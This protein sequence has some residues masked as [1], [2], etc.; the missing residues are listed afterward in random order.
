MDDTAAQ[1]ASVSITIAVTRDRLT[2]RKR[3]VAS[4]AEGRRRKGRESGRHARGN[5]VC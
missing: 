4:S 5:S 1:P 2:A 3:R